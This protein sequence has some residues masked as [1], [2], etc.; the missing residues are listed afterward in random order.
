MQV[1]I[2][3]INLLSRRFRGESDILTNFVHLVLTVGAIQTITVIRTN[4]TS[5][6]WD[7][8]ELCLSLVEYWHVNAPWDIT[9]I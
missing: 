2:A 5:Q 1:K 6:F 4:V 9:V 8:L 3:R 7:K